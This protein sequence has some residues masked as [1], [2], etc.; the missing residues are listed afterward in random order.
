MLRPC[1]PWL[2]PVGRRPDHK[3]GGDAHGSGGRLREIAGPTPRTAVLGRN[4]HTPVGGHALLHAELIDTVSMVGGTAPSRGEVAQTSD[5]T[6]APASSPDRTEVEGPATLRDGQRVTVRR[7]TRDDR[8]SLEEFLAALSDNSLAVRFFAP[9]PRSTALAELERG[10]ASKDR[11]PLVLLVQKGEREEIVA[12]A[13]Y[14][15]DGPDA[16][17]AEVAFL[18][19]EAYQGH[20]CA[21]LLLWRLARAARAVGIREFHASVLMENDQMLEVFRGSGFPSEEWW[22]PDAVQVTFP[23][24][25][26]YEPPPRPGPGFPATPTAS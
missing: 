26:K 10:L 5:G 2:L 13:E 1:L 3:L 11:C 4:P 23:I 8:R 6:L 22:G 16:P 24:S 7:L 15:R 18:V 12:H 19:A 9:V 25:E 17:A 21:T 20:G 14:V